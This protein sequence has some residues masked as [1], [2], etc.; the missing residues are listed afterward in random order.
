M[1]KKSHYIPTLCFAINLLIY[2]IF[3]ILFRYDLNRKLYYEFHTE[4]VPILILM[5]ISISVLFFVLLY[6]RR[7]YTKMYYALIPIIL[8][9]IILFISLIKVFR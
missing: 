3:K 7:K 8:Y 6:L 9:I 1:K 2:L 4:I 5:N